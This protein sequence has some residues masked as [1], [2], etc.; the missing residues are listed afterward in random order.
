M[1]VAIF[2]IDGTLTDTM[3]VDMECFVRALREELGV[4]PPAHWH[5]L[6]DVTDS[7]IVAEACRVAGKSPPDPRSEAKMANRVGELLSEIAAVEPSRFLPIPGAAFILEE[8]KHRDWGVGMATGAWRPS[9]RI[10]LKTAALPVAGVPLVTSSDFPARTAIISE[11]VRRAGGDPSADTVVYFGDGVW[12]GRAAEQVGCH[13]V[14][15]GSG[16]R[17]ERLAA[18]GARYVTPDFT[19]QDALLTHLDSLIS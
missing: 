3:A 18:A 5:T 16:D 2:D 11:S 19:A 6:D 15:I 1:N 7:T 13:F 12:D 14:G 4:E 10:K 9:A 8:L 17:G